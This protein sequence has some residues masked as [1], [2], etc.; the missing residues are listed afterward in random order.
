MN[1]IISNNIIENINNQTGIKAYYDSCDKNDYRALAK[2]I[3]LSDSLWFTLAKKAKVEVAISLY[4]R[5]LS[6]EQLDF[7]LK[8]K[9]V[10]AKHSLIRKDSALYYAPFKKIDELIDSQWLSY[11][12]AASWLYQD[13]NLSASQIRKIALSCKGRVLVR[14][15]G[16]TQA[17]PD[18]DE[19]VALL[20]N[21]KKGLSHFDLDRVF[22][23]RPELINYYDKLK[24]SPFRVAFANSWHLDTLEDQLKILGRKTL[25]GNIK[26]WTTL[27]SN[28]YTKVEIVDMIRSI[29]DKES[30]F[31]DIKRA[32]NR[33]ELAPGSPLVMKYNNINTDIDK[34]RANYFSFYN[35]I[36][37][38][39]LS[40]KEKVNYSEKLLDRS[41][42]DIKILD[43]SD[44]FYLNWPKISA[45]ISSQLALS[46]PA[47][48]NFWSLINNWQGN[49][50]ELI[51]ASKSL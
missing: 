16:N 27:L 11:D 35:S 23:Y 31:S 17:F 10:W 2:N 50:T 24:A 22:F 4:H 1:N 21:N 49:L 47:W 20:N 45:D 37:D 13:N 30:D 25:N 9:R 40:F 41:L 3:Y 14:Q 39:N 34:E 18:I 51:I 38:D 36:V 29:I 46:Y 32:L 33:W 26:V 12:L 5:A 19:V 48:R 15:L 7:A 42:C 28:P 44:I 43:T 8:D 6:N